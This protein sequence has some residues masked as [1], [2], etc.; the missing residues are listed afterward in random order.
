MATQRERLR[1]EGAAHVVAKL[2]LIKTT[3]KSYDL[4]L[5]RQVSWL[6]G[7]SDDLVANGDG[8]ASSDKGEHSDKDA[9]AESHSEALRRL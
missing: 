3:L 5:V 6:E 9:G 1:G 7:G 4:D 2:A 8:T